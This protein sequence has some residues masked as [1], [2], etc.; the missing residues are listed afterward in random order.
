MMKR[1]MFILLLTISLMMGVLIVRLFWLQ[2]IATRQHI[3]GSFVQQSVAQRGLTIILDDGRADFY[4]R[5]QQRLTGK[6]VHMLA[7]FPLHQQYEADRQQLQ[8]IASILDEPL[9]AWLA[10]VSDMKVPHLWPK[11]LSVQQAEQLRAL[12]APGFHVVPYKLRYY[13]PFLAAHLLGFT[14]QYP[15]RIL[16]QYSDRL[17]SGQLSL[18][19]AIG[20]A[21]LELSLDPLLHGRARTA[22]T[23]FTDAELRPLS[24]LSARLQMPQRHSLLPLKVMTTIDRSIQQ[25]IEELADEQ[26]MKRGAIV[27][28]DTA[29][30]DVIAMVSRPQMHDDPFDFADSHWAN[31]ALQ[32]ATPGSVFKIVVAAAALEGRYVK[33]D[34]QFHCPGAYA[35]SA[36]GSYQL[37][38]WK[39]DGHGHLTMRQAFAQSCN[40]VFAQLVERMPPEELQ[41][42]AHKLGL[43]QRVGWS[44]DGKPFPLRQ[45]VEEQSGT[46]FAAES[47]SHDLGAR[48]QTGIGQRD[49]TMTPLQAAN[50]IVTLLHDGEV[51]SPRAVTQLRQAN[52]RIVRTFPRQVIIPRREGISA[53]TARTLL[54]WMGEVVSHGTGQPLQQAIWDVAGKSGTAQAVVDKQPMLNRWF[55]GYGPRH[56]PRYAVAI[57]IQDEEV[58][59][60]GERSGQVLNLFKQ[61]MDVLSKT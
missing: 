54:Q 61:V 49:V 22:V 5:H 19:S 55:V 32:A 60:R 44:Q 20:A 6:P 27:V 24:G 46:L 23:L 59:G 21:G 10:Y 9:D 14:S 43:M 15:E 7:L 33:A 37:P 29:H 1:R 47:V 2:L 28:L 50:V 38:C 17:K 57:L 35:H 11:P 39:K 34:H 40:V 3:K 31:K 30:A 36:L 16:R 48:L 8:A 53:R 4:D 25:Q 52:N 41:A 58:Y 42:V 13:E 45:F 26:Q 56:R 18:H 12:Q 51:Q